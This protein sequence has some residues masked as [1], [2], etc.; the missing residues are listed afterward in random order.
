MAIR[1]SIGFAPLLLP[2]CSRFAPVLGTDTV[3]RTYRL[4]CHCIKSIGQT[5]MLVE[6]FPFLGGRRSPSSPFRGDE[7]A[8]VR[9]KACL[10][11]GCGWAVFGVT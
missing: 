6:V 5:L 2:F 9:S 8:G 1:E 3:T 4:T 11:Q 7:G 10:R